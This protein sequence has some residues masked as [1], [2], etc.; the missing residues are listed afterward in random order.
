MPLF[1]CGSPWPSRRRPRRRGPSPDRHRNADTSLSSRRST[2]PF[3]FLV[4]LS[5]VES[6]CGSGGTIALK[7]P[8]PSTAMLAEKIAD[9]VAT[10]SEVLCAADNICVMHIGGG[11]SRLRGGSCAWPSSSTSSTT[12]PWVKPMPA[13]LLS[14]DVTVQI[15]ELSCGGCP[16]CGSKRDVGVR[17]SPVRVVGRCEPCCGRRTSPRTALCRRWRAG[18]AHRGRGRG[19]WPRRC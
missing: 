3:H 19:W 6:C 7:N 5:G 14:G 4:E 15:V 13:F 8:A 17:G 11:L 2:R 10:G 1:R 9:I 12:I 18:S 16:L